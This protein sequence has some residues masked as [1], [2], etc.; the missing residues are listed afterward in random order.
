MALGKTSQCRSPLIWPRFVAS[1]SSHGYDWCLKRHHFPTSKSYILYSAWWGNKNQCMSPKKGVLHYRQTVW[2]PANAQW[3]WWWHLYMMYICKRWTSLVC[4]AS[5]VVAQLEIIM[6]IEAYKS[7][8][9]SSEVARLK[10][11]G[12]PSWIKQRHTTVWVLCNLFNS[13]A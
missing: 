5:S 7:S 8:F 13:S 4:F 3:L 1:S 10:Y 12:D 6:F 2:A 9:L 11:V